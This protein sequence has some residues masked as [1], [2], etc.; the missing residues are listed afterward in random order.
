[1]N[2]LQHVFGIEISNSNPP[3][4]LC[5][6]QKASSLKQTFNSR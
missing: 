2:Q 1:M 3:K 6:A 5:V 4:V